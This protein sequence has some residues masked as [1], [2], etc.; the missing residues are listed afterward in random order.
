[1]ENLFVYWNILEA[2]LKDSSFFIPCLGLKG[3]VHMKSCHFRVYTFHEETA[4]QV[5]STLVNRSEFRSG[6]ALGQT[7]SF[8]ILKQGSFIE[9]RNCDR[10]SP[11]VG[12]SQGDLS[13]RDSGSKNHTVGCGTFGCDVS[14]GC[15]ENIT[16]I[17][18][19]CC[20]KYQTI[21]F[22]TCYFYF[23]ITAG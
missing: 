2:S 23:C 3:A 4:S 13:R 1:M 19:Y 21:I 20:E 22:N 8:H 5:P 12:I 16:I 6:P 7:H 9:P 11:L 14:F 17:Q 18:N 10:R 15:I